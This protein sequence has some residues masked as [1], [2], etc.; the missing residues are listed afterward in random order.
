MIKFKKTPNTDSIAE[1]KNVRTLSNMSRTEFI[2]VTAL[3]KMFVFEFVT[4]VNG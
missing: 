3:D 2:S 1:E 4:E